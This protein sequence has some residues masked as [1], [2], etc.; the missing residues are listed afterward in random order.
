MNTH[1]PPSIELFDTVA[2]I[3]DLPEHGLIAGEVGAVVEVLASDA[4]E[5]EFCDENGQTYASQ[6]LRANQIVAL[7][8]HGHPLR[9]VAREAIMAA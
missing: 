6:T 9:A 7:H 5:V 3:C 1:R 8:N 2:L 4:F